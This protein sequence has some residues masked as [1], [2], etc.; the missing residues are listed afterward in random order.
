MR[1]ATYHGQQDIRVEDITPGDV[2]P[3]EVR[4]DISAG[5]ICGSD[6]HEYAAGPIFIPSDDPHP[7]TGDV[8]PVTMGHEFAG[9]ISEVGDKAE[10][11]E[12]QPVAVNPVVWCGDC[13]YCTAGKY[14]LCESGGFIGLSGGGGGFA[15]SV[16]V[17][18]VQAIPLPEDVSV[19]HGALV[20]PLTVAL[21]AVRGS[22]IQAGDSVAVFGSGPIGLGVIQAARAAGATDIIASEPRDA[23]RDRAAESGA[24]MT[25]DPM[26]R[27]PVETTSAA[28]NGG[29]DV[30]FEAAGI[31]TTVAQAI[32]STKHQGGVTIVS[33]FEEGVDM[34]LN[35]I[36]LGERSLTGTLGYEGGPRSAREFR[37][38]IQMLA[39]GRFDPGP[40]V[41]D[42]IDLDEIIQSGFDP[43]LD[44]ESDQ[45]KILVEP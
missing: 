7:V 32:Q 24:T 22:G 6:L 5:G 45:V 12:G 14:H 25:I 19:E 36:V 2:G 44:S 4:V 16:V 3:N 38:T 8:A 27:D 20:E 31:A 13:R 23:R 30:A 37:P 43:L 11:T 18:A 35:D 40:L 9:T 21:H 1:A 42:Q 10:M 41:T 34:Q 39:D 15:E 17:N 33:I 28:T 29:V 26:E